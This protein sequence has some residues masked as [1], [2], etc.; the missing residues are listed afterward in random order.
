[1]TMHTQSLD[2]RYVKL[3]HSKQMEVRNGRI[4]ADILQRRTMQNRKAQRAF[5]ARQKV[6]V[7]TLEARLETAERAYTCLKEDYER[8]SIAH[9]KLGGSESQVGFDLEIKREG[10]NSEDGSMAMGVEALKDDLDWE[11]RWRGFGWGE[12]TD[13][14]EERNER[15]KELHDLLACL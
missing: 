8:L 12:S 4:D 2:P 1:M 9:G 15:L 3:V 11:C 14:E 5:R 6:H 13:G 7:E 10:L